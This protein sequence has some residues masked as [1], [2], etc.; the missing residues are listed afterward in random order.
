MGLEGRNWARVGLGRR[1]PKL[2]EAS[3]TTRGQRGQSPSHA[4][5]RPADVGEAVADGRF[6]DRAPPHPEAAGLNPCTEEDGRASPPGGIPPRRPRPE[7][8]PSPGP[9]RSLRT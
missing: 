9:V 8:A 1:L 7:P 6:T 2:M 3:R 5:M 4:E